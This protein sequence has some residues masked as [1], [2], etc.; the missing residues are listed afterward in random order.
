M[1][2]V[3]NQFRF[4]ALPHC[5]NIAYL[6][7]KHQTHVARKA[8]SSAKVDL[9]HFILSRHFSLVVQLHLLF[10]NVRASAFAPSTLYAVFPIKIHP[11]QKEERN[12]ISLSPPPSPPIPTLTT[13]SLS[14]SKEVGFWYL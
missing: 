14:I 9:K 7:P 13:I 10:Y 3:F 5:Q 2:I 11:L 12:E 4:Q 8:S 6:P 1:Y